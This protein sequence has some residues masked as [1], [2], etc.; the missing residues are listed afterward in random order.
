MRHREAKPQATKRE[1]RVFPDDQPGER[2]RLERTTQE[3]LWLLI[4][5]MN[6]H[7]GEAK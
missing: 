4:R 2:R 7:Q 5:E 6:N 3:F 1:E